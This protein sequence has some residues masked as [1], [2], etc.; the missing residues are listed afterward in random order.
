MRNLNSIA[1]AKSIFQIEKLFHSDAL[2][3]L[4]K[5]LS[6]IP[7]I[8]DLIDQQLIRV[9]MI[10]DANIVYSELRWRLG[11]RR[12]PHA[13]SAL[14]EAIDSGVMVL[15]APDF[16]KT[17]IE[18]HLS[19][20]AWETSCSIADANREWNLLKSKLH[21]SNLPIIREQGF[22]ADPDDLPYK[23]AGATLGLPIYTRDP[24]LAAMGAPVVYLC[25]DMALRNHARARSITFGVILGSTYSLTIG[26]QTLQT[27][28]QLIKRL[29]TGF[30]RLPTW[31]QALILGGVA[32]ALIHPKS[33]TK[34]LRLCESIYSN[35]NEAKNSLSN[36][37]MQLVDQFATANAVAEHSK[38][39]I[40][41]VMPAMKK[42]PAIVFAKRVCTI[43][44]SP[45]SIGEI[46]H[47]IQSE[48]YISKSKNFIAYL[49]RVLRKNDQFV[50]ISRGM[51]R[52][53][54]GPEG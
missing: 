20:I 53:T 19:K 40:E 17:E 13:R 47:R 2:P 42:P 28:I 54:Q 48:G 21:F 18:E 9:C 16:L 7:G 12:N 1:E 30:Y 3:K 14:E 46:A 11:K 8:Q 32:V 22:V 41:A 27:A 31:V 44:R 52:L 34:L 26:I 5:A 39:E 35:I 33:R 24:H 29:M 15:I 25:I 23:L 49:Q 43:C 6:E 45:L 38:R 50:E 51:W 36:E 4:R 10:T 37:F